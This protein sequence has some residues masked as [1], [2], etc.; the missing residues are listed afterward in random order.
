MSVL[1]FSF[2]YTE[3]NGQV[4]NTDL[5]EEKISL[6]TDRT[7]YISG[8]QVQFSAYLYNNSIAG[9]DSQNK[10]IKSQD[11]TLSRVFYVEIITPE[12]EKIAK[13]KYLY[14]KSCGSG[15]ITIP[16]DVAT[17]NYYIR[18]YTKFM[19]NNGPAAYSYARLKIVNPFKSDILTY[20]HTNTQTPKDSVKLEDTLGRQELVT[21]LLNKEEYS[22]REQV[23]I[24]INGLDLL[25]NTIID[26][27]LTVIPDSSIVEENKVLPVVDKTLYNNYYYPE[28][29]GL[30]LTGRLKD[31]KSELSLSNTMVNLSILDDCKDFM[32]TLTDSTG[33]F[34]FRMPSFIGSNDIFLCTETLVDSKTNI[35]IDNDFCSIKVKLPT[36]PFHLTEMEKVVAYNMALNAQIASQFNKEIPKDSSKYKNKAFYGEPQER[37]FLDKYIQLP[38]IEDYINEIIPILKIRKHRGEKYFKVYSTQAEMDIFKPLV[39]LDLVAID[40]PKKILSLSPQSISHIEVIDFPYV[41]GSITYGGIISFFSKK[42]DFAGVDLPNS[43]V[44]LDFNFLTDG[45]KSYSI[46]THGEHQPDYRNT[47]IWEPNVVLGSEKSKD[48]YFNTSDT[49]GKYIVLLR[50]ITSQGKEFTCKKSFI[51]RD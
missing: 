6:F 4:I 12:G 43:G 36:P 23:K 31:N 28:T 8:E 16:K 47:L 30:S 3:S 18:A 19:R 17:G 48:L 50:G 26:L 45:S 27:N 40:N 9:I 41:K 14:E 33:R 44:F 49:P 39:L 51:V 10:N 13:G 37:L 1:I 5:N 22:T 42:G 11:Q 15:F 21:V 24:Q 7:L 29:N 2:G 46:N 20:N 35:F 32:A 25:K 38:T 34:F